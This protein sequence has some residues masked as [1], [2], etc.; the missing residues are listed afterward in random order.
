MDAL[1]AD[2]IPDPTTAGDFLRR[3]GYDD[4]VGLMDVQNEYS[5]M[6]WSLNPKNKQEN[7]FDHF[8]FHLIR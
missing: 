8:A 1:G 2:R 6:I 4:V 7:T 5:R 3:F